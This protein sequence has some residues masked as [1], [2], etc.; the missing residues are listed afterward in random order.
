[1]RA[2]GALATGR[3]RQTKEKIKAL[4]YYGVDAYG[5][6]GVRH[7]HERGPRVSNFPAEW[8]REG[9]EGR[10]IEYHIALWRYSEASRRAPGLSVCECH[11][12]GFCLFVC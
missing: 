1:M 12:A 2:L 8:E 7:S 11:G 6:E 9:N 3:P 10:G 4:S 5:A